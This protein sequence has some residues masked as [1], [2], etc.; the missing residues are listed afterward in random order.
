MHKLASA[1]LRATSEHNKK[2]LHLVTKK[3]TKI[4]DKNT[5]YENIFDILV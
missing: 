1:S 3:R 4:N 2:I 5:A